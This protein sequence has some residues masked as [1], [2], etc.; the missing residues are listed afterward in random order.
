LFVGIR[1]APFGKYEGKTLP[2]I[3]MQD[4]D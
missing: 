3:I 2:E 1:L 4:P